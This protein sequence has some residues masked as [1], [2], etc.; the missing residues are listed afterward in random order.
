MKLASRFLMIQTVYRFLNQELQNDI[1]DLYFQTLIEKFKLIDITHPPHVQNEEAL[2]IMKGMLLS[3]LEETNTYG[4]YYLV[5]KIQMFCVN[6]FE[7]QFD[8]AHL[9]ANIGPLKINCDE[10]DHRVKASF[11][12]AKEF[13]SYLKYHARDIKSEFNIFRGKASNSKIRLHE[14][15]LSLIEL[16]LRLIYIN[17][18]INL[19]ERAIEAKKVFDAFGATD[20]SWSNF[21]RF[22]NKMS[23]EIE[24]YQILF[25]QEYG[26]C[27]SMPKESLRP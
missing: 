3:A 5:Y 22:C 19:I 15:D 18:D 20:S 26:L 25:I 14:K 2:A 27:S 23:H 10:F 12:K 16:K 13:L 24:Q 11:S 21:K 7:I 4:A 1:T 8:L 17:Q 6:L 9:H